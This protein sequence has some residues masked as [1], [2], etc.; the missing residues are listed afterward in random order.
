MA[1]DRTTRAENMRKFDH[2][3]TIN[4]HPVDDISLEFFYKPHTITLLT[5]SIAGLLYTAFTRLAICYH[6][7][8]FPEDVGEKINILGKRYVII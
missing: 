8:F 3:S 2:F 6:M 5:V 1:E 4:E 7:C